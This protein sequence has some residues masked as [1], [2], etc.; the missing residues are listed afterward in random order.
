[1]VSLKGINYRVIKDEQTALNLYNNDKVDTTELSSQNVE[2]NKDKEGFDTNLESATYYIQINT[3]TNKDL[4]NKDLR[5]ALAQ[6]I[7][8]KSYVEHNLNDGSKP[9]D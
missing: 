3:Q 7:D 9:I 8:K 1:H 2:S 5:A 4:Q 6:A